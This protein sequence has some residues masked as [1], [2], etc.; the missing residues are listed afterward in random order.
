MR[1]K[2]SCLI[3]ILVGNLIVNIFLSSYVSKLAMDQFGEAGLAYAVAF[4]TVL[5]ILF[6]EITPKTLAFKSAQTFALAAA[7][8]LYLIKRTVY[9]V[10]ELLDR[11]SEAVLN[12][13]LMEKEEE[14]HLS[15]DELSTMVSLGARQGV[16]YGWEK[17]LI[18]QI[19]E[20]QEVFAVERM[21]PRPD[22]LAVELNQSRESIEEQVK[23]VPHS[24]IPVYD[25]DINYVVSYFQVKDFLLHPE[26]S[27]QEIMKPVYVI[28]EMKPMGD[29]L[30]EMQ[31]SNLKL[32]VLVDEYGNTQGIITLE[33]VLETIFGEWRDPETLSPQSISKIEKKRYRIQGNTSCR[34]INAYFDEELFDEEEVDGST[35]IAGFMMGEL[36]RMPR[37]SDTVEL[38]GMILKIKRL[39]NRRI[40]DVELEFAKGSP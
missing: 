28:P 26:K 34:E 5:L 11:T 18:E 6:S 29:L 2:S 32:A 13:F 3:V 10:I 20:F 17:K 33:D 31:R 16:F 24:K 25:Q 4:V 7:P 12:T 36:N 22:I 39:E 21:V 15:P 38:E 23:G 37:L 19:F 14:A 35:T 8:L 27:L 30:E 9:P 40:L 1:N